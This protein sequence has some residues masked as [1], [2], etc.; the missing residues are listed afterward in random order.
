MARYDV[1]VIGLGRFGS[2]LALRLVEEGRRVLGV[3]VDEAAV[4]ALADQVDHL[5]I[6]EARDEETLRQL[7]IRPDT[8]VVLGMTHVAASL[9]TATALNELGVREIW[10]KA[11][12]RQHVEAL[13]RLGVSR[14]I[15]PE[16]EAGLAMASEILRR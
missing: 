5:A 2:A 4:T 11:G 10:A 6:A 7:D 13:T 14:I 9:M 3:D 8:L 15:Q 12:S 16:R 1:A